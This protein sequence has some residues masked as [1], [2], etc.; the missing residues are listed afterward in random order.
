MKDD[1]DNNALDISQILSIHAL[2]KA[3]VQQTYDDATVRIASK[4]KVLRRKEGK[5]EI[6]SI[7]YEEVIRKAAAM[8]YILRDKNFEKWCNASKLFEYAALL[9]EIHELEDVPKNLLIEACDHVYSQTKKK[10]MSPI[11]LTRI[12]ASMSLL[13]GRYNIKKYFDL[14]VD[15]YPS[16]QSNDF[17]NDMSFVIKNCSASF[18]DVEKA[19][20]EAA[21]IIN[22]FYNLN[23][24][25]NQSGRR[26]ARKFT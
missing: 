16:I 11:A 18:E 17:R 20:C 25:R 12:G 9:D 13:Y 21:L 6:F 22:K 1:I 3:F 26:L 2:S 10:M 7:D 8:S 4:K 19:S 24:D 15:V 14:L 23:I 5:I